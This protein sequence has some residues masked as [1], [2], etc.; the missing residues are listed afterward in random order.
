[1]TTQTTTTEEK[2]TMPLPC[3]SEDKIDEIETEVYKQSGWLKAAAGFA[4]IAVVALGSFNGV[5]LSK[6]ST[7]ETLLTNNQ[8]SIAEVKKDIIALDQRIKDI[9]ER[10]KFLDQNG[11]VKKLR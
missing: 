8:V 10:H 5:V 4:G 7:I 6:L 2:C 1:M 9:E 11:V 3:Q